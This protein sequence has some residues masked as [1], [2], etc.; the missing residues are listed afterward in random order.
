MTIEELKKLKL[1]TLIRWNNPNIDNF[2]SQYCYGLVQCVD[3]NSTTINW[4]NERSSTYTTTYVIY[5]EYT[6]LTCYTWLKHATVVS[7]QED[8]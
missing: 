3:E 2:N 7:Q 4:K 5:A 8:N 6:G 1:G